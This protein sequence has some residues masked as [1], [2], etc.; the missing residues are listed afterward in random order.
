MGGIKLKG[1]AI[2]KILLSS[3]PSILRRKLGVNIIKN[4]HVSSF[5]FLSFKNS[6]TQ[7]FFNVFTLLTSTILYKLFHFFSI[8]FFFSVTFFFKT[9]PRL[10]AVVSPSL[11]RPFG[12][13]LVKGPSPPLGTS[14]TAPLGPGMAK[15]SDFGRWRRARKLN[16]VGPPNVNLQPF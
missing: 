13:G 5:H 3:Y 1:K 14:N 12:M 10:A 9:N 11:L 15:A 8:S 6:E 2:K 4:P 16:G 7:L